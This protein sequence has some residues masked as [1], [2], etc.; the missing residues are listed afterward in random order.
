MKNSAKILLIYIIVCCFFLSAACAS[1]KNLSDGETGG[2]NDMAVIY[3]TAGDSTEKMLLADTPAA[4]ELTKRLENGDVA[5]QVNDYGGFEKVGNLGFSLEQSDSR[6][7][8]ES[9]DVMLYLGSRIVFFYG[10][11]S[12]SYTRLGRMENLSPQQLREF[13]CAGEGEMQIVLSLQQPRNRNNKI[14]V[15]TGSDGE[16]QILS[17]GRNL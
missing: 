17:C 1:S 2:E 5:V 10:S 6:L 7:T 16:R 11:N 8:A 15:S 14:T 12:Y 4:A 9:E 13:L 3:V